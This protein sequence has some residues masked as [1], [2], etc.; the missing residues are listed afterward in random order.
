MANKTQP[1]SAS[2]DDFLDAVDGDQRREDCRRLVEL[3]QEVTGEPPVMWGPSIVGFG[4]YHYRYASGREDDAPLLGFSPRKANLT[5]YAAGES[6]E[7]AAL[8]ERLGPHTS[9][10]ACLYLKGLADVDEAVLVELLELG[11]AESRAQ[12]VSS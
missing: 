12:D 1:T 2:V 8:L 6:D 9:S 5:V 3:M 7:R 11:L 10:V 4:S